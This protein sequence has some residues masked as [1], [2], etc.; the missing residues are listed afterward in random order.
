V[1][2]D[3]QEGFWFLGEVIQAKDQDR[4]FEHIGGVSRVKSVAVTEHG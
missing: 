3:V 4:M 2:V 1:G